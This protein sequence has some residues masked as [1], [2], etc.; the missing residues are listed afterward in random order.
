MEDLIRNRAKSL[1]ISKYI[2]EII[3]GKMSSDIY[4]AAKKVYPLRRVE[5]AKTEQK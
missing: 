3:L 4:K 5:I 2:Q 1:E